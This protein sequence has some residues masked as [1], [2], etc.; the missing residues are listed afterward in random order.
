MQRCQLV[1]HG[2]GV[3]G[4]IGA[5]GFRPKK[6]LRMNSDVSVVAKLDAD[7]SNVQPQHTKM[8]SPTQENDEASTLMQEKRELCIITLKNQIRIAVAMCCI[9]QAKSTGVE[10]LKLL[11]CKRSEFLIS[12]TASQAHALPQ[13]N[14]LP[15]SELE[16]KIG[17]LR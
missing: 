16:R 5:A 10:P 13:Q 1:T 7:A 11:E 15:R 12:R 4:L 2:L 14:L 3:G 8:M 9:K 17:E 6:R